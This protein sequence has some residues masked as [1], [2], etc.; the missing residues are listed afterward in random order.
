MARAGRLLALGAAL[1]LVLGVAPSAATAAETLLVLGVARDGKA[2]LKLS[3]QIQDRIGRSGETVA[4]APRLSASER[5]CVAQDCLDTLA[6]REQA[7]I[8][9]TASV[10]KSG[11]GNQAMA[12]LLYDA[13]RRKPFEASS[14]CERCMPE[15]L[16]LRVGELFERLLKEH[17]DRT[18]G[19]PVAQ[20]QAAQ[21]AGQRPRTPSSEPVRPSPAQASVPTSPGKAETETPAQQPQILYPPRMQPIESETEVPR[22]LEGADHGRRPL[23]S[24]SP[25]RKILAGV[26]G[27]VAGAA[28]ITAIALNVTNGQ[29]TSMD[30]AATPGTPKFCVTDY[31]ALYGTGYALAGLSLVGL[32]VT[33]F[34][35]SGDSQSG[36]GTGKLAQRD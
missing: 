5:L 30:C 11:A 19:E 4:P 31:R 14:E 3:R 8:V 18:A 33:L 12:A 23:L 1:G 36:R 16:A 28:L 9:L 2:D 20:A 29:P 32:G 34:W 7:S 15:T 26:L 10:Q 25:K 24:L 27:G 17:R 6:A 13:V 21:P 22:G 35:P